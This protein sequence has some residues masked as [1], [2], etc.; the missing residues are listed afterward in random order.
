MV[1]NEVIFAVAGGGKTQSIVNRCNNNPKKRLI[2][3]FT[4]LGQLEL[5]RRLEIGCP[6]SRPEVVG[7]YSFLIDHFLKP[8]ICDAFP[9]REYLGFNFKYRPERYVQGDRRY[10]DAD[11]KVGKE[12]ISFVALK[13]CN[14]GEKAAIH[15]LEAIYDEIIFDE[16]QDF[17]ASDLDLLKLLMESSIDTYIVGDPR[18]IVYETNQGD[19]RNSKYRGIDKVDWYRKQEDSGLITITE[20]VENYRCNQQIVKFSNEIFPSCLNLAP[21]IS[22]QPTTF[23]E[24]IGLYRITPGQFEDYVQTYS[25]LVLRWSASSGRRYEN[26]CD[27]FNFGEVKG[28]S[29]DHVLIIPTDPILKF[30]K[31]REIMKPQARAKLYVAVT[32]ARHS[33][34]FILGQR[35]EAQDLIPWDY[36]C[37]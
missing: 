20:M 15:R 31:S 3:T 24:H 10:F 33:V 27:I 8:Y 1:T 30:L 22:A 37:I 34:A 7:W 25:P 13:I 2:I 32:R 35:Q 9:H 14:S 19:R 4:E 28:T 21:A 29:S 5:R 36:H 17:V 12:G 16:A 26:V 6:G 18:Q 11:G 23:E